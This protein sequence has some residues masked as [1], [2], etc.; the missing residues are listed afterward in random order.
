MLWAILFDVR[1]LSEFYGLHL[2]VHFYPLSNL[3]IR[4]PNSLYSIHLTKD[5]LIRFAKIFQEQ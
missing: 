4:G 2:A 5:S 3:I 1:Y